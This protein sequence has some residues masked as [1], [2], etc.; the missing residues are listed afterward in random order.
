MPEA[1]AGEVKAGEEDRN[2][3]PTGKYTGDSFAEE[4]L[5]VHITAAMLEKIWDGTK[6]TWGEVV[7]NHMT[8]TPT[9][10]LEAAETITECKNVPVRRIVRLDSSGTTYNFKAYLSLLPGVTPAGVWTKSPVEGT[11][12]R[13]P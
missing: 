6:M 12:R 9:S 4:T 1:K 3:D 7:K 11:T 2:N 13:G 10:P 8:G 5:R